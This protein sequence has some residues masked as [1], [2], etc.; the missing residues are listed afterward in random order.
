LG[1]GEALRVHACGHQ[2]AILVI[3]TESAVLSFAKRPHHAIL[4]QNQRVT[5]PAGSHAHE[6]DG[7]APER[8]R[9]KPR[10]QQDKTQL[11]VV[12]GARGPDRAVLRQRCSVTFAGS[13]QDGRSAKQLGA[14]HAHRQLAVVCCRTLS[15]R[16]AKVYA[17][18]Q[19]AGP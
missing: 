18:N 11:A 5:E 6:H 7:R 2:P 12:A 9:P 16:K 10:R 15:C 3:E 17:E 1:A 4:R 14:A 8:L 13:E 19:H